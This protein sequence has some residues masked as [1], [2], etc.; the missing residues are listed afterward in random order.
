[1]IEDRCTIPYAVSAG[2]DPS[3]RKQIDSVHIRAVWVRRRYST[4]RKLLDTETFRARTAS[5]D[6]VVPERILIESD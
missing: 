4:S 2:V 1:M 6:A 5:F 3:S